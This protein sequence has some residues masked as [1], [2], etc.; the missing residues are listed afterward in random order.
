MEIAGVCYSLGQRI[1]MRFSG[2]HEQLDVHQ[3]VFYTFLCVVEEIGD[4]V[5][6]VRFVK[7]NPLDADYYVGPR[8][9]SGRQ[10]SSICRWRTLDIA[11]DEIGRADCAHRWDDRTDSSKFHGCGY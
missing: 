6:C 8:S 2:Q 4:L 7:R 1:A 11:K 5:A 10:N 3:Y 9:H